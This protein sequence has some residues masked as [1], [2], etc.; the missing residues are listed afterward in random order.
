MSES[1]NLHSSSD[2]KLEQKEKVALAKSRRSF[3]P[4]IEMETEDSNELSLKKHL[5]LLGK[6]LIKVVT[7]FNRLFPSSQDL[8]AL[9]Q[10]FDMDRDGSICY[11]EF[12]KVL[13]SAQLSQRVQVLV[14]KAWDETGR[15]GFDTCTGHDIAKAF[16]KPE[17]LSNFLDQFNTTKNGNLD[18][19]VERDDFDR[20][21]QDM[22][23]CVPS[24]EYCIK[25]ISECWGVQETAAAYMCPKAV[26]KLLGLFRQSVIKKSNFNIDEYTLRNTFRHFDL[27]HSGNLSEIE[28]H[29]LCSNVGLDLTQPELE[30]LFAKID[31]NRNG[32]IEFEEFLSTVLEDPYK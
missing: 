7:V 15:N 14:Q 13:C 5:L 18:G 8:T 2:I 4:T 26:E 12:S 17:F 1:K 29:G 32:T 23:V 9:C 3:R 20:A 6:F 30:A 25:K 11:T 22:A 19:I 21:F 28:L 31:V 16:K 27:D 24:E 10:H